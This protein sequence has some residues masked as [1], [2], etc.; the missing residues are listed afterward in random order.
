MLNNPPPEHKGHGV[1]S[2]L[3]QL[4]PH[5][6]SL[7]VSVQGVELVSRGSVCISNCIV[8][9]IIVWVLVLVSLIG[10]VGSLEAQPL[11]LP[12]TNIPFSFYVQQ[13]L[14]GHK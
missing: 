13:Y 1:E 12:H 4:F 8:L 7:S 9:D 11:Q 6:W 2:D 3:V 14:F 5:G 10:G